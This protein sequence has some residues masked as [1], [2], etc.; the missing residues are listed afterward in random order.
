MIAAQPALLPAAIEQK[1][2]KMQ[3]IL[4][5]LGLVS[6][7]VLLACTGH[8]TDSPAPAADSIKSAQA[9]APKKNVDFIQPP[10]TDYTG[11]YVDRYKNGVIKFTGFFRFGKRHGQWMAFYI[12]GEKWSECFYDKGIKQGASNVFYPNGIPQFRGWYKNDLKDSTWTFYDTLG[13]VIEVKHFRNDE[14][15][16][17]R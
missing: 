17:L 11:D 1:D 2:M 12:N 3:K 14:E 15:L 7:V 8:V 16:P 10:D 13:R 9:E 6:C 5:A 4:T